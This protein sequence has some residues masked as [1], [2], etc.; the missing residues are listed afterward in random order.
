MAKW[1]ISFLLAFSPPSALAVEFAL[2]EQSIDEAVT[3]GS[4]L[5]RQVGGYAVHDWVV[6]E[7]E[8]TLAVLS[9]EGVDAVVLRTP[10][11]ALRN[12][13]YILEKQDKNLTEDR[14]RQELERYE[15][16]VE[17]VVYTHSLGN[18]GFLQ[19]FGEGQLRLK[20]NTT[21]EP[22]SVERVGPSPAEFIIVGEEGPESGWAGEVRY[23]FD[24][25]GL[26]A[27]VDNIG[28]SQVTLLF[29]DAWGKR[30]EFEINLGNYR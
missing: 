20:Y 23:A 24:L 22:D 15:G 27:E 2:D 13:A 7:A 11:E 16:R 25:Q 3:E 21:L 4:D 28:T 12:L 26:E 5:G 1:L 14:I 8:E 19:D 30:H 6:W 10:F 18:S 17:F 9:P 29:T